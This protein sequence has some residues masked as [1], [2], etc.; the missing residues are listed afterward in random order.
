MKLSTER[1]K[2]CLSQIFTA[3]LHEGIVPGKLRQ[4]AI[5]P[6]HKGE[7][8]MLCSNYGP[9]SI[10][11]IFRKILE[12][13]MHKRLTSFLDRYNILYKH[14]NSFQRGK[15]TEHAI[16]DLHTN[17]IKAVESR[18]KSCSIFPDFAKAF[19]TVNY[20][21]LLEKLKNYGI[22]GLPLNWFKSYLSGRYQCV[23]INN[24]KSDNKAIVC[25][26]PQGSVFLIYINDIYKSAPKVCFHL[27]ADG[28]CL[29]YSNKSYKKM[30]L[31]LIFL[32]ITLQTC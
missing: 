31:R 28:T 30:E 5:Y 22:R 26:V 29:F 18:E 19:D 4:A 3:S 9:I 14:Q 12:K 2:K 23:K 21:I 8:K 6:I 24:A 15:S 17:I 20:D 13:L 32:L 11:P 27:F 25:G 1:I 10:L 7:T 16:I